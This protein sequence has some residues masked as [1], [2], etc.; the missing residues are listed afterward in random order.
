MIL[1][2]TFKAFKLRIPKT[3][4]SAMAQQ[5]KTLAAKTNNL[6]LIPRTCMIEGG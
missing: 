5:V 3:G 4:T 1:C 6:S 2:K